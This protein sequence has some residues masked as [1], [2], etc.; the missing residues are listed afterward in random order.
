M[1]LVLAQRGRRIGRGHFGREKCL[2]IAYQRVIGAAPTTKIAYVERFCSTLFYSSTFRC[3]SHI[4]LLCVMWMHS[5]RWKQREQE[6]VRVRECAR[7]G[8]RGIQSTSLGTS[9]HCSLFIL[10][11]SHRFG[12]EYHST[13]ITG[14]RGDRLPHRIHSLSVAIDV[15]VFSLCLP[16]SVSWQGWTMWVFGCVFFSLLSILSVHTS[17]INP[18][19]STVIYLHLYLFYSHNLFLERHKQNQEN[20]EVNRDK[21]RNNTPTA[22]KKLILFFFLV[23]CCFR[24]LRIDW[25]VGLAVYLQVKSKS[26]HSTY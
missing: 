7:D 9:N 25:T 1:I 13:N 24:S 12:F 20:E 23:L 16:S 8:S 26:P 15:W 18:R 5:I 22:K 4:T 21:S 17:G 2:H 19:S 6:S 3:A 14:R 11:G 10:N